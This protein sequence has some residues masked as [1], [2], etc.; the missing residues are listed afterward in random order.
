MSEKSARQS[1]K[2]LRLPT[3]DTYYRWRIGD[4]ILGK[5]IVAWWKPKRALLKDGSIVYL[6][7]KPKKEQ[8]Y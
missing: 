6:T 8:R 2:D 1:I 5:R 7:N 3:T 4:R